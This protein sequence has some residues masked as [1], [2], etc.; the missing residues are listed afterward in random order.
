MINAFI[1]AAIDRSRT[2]IFILL[3]ILVSGIAAF[4]A[5]PKEA[6]PDVAIPIIY[7]SV[8]YEGISPDDAV[9]LL[10]RP[11][12]KE[13]KT[14]EGIKEMRSVGSEGHA[15][16]TL[17]F[18]AG[19]DSDSA[20]DDVREK[21]DIA[22][23]K[24][25]D[26]AEEPSINEV[27]VA[28]FPVLNIALSGAVPERVKLAAAKDLKEEIEGVAGVLKVDIGGE[29]EEMMEIII[30]PQVLESYQLD[31]SSILNIV[32]QNNQLVAA[33]AVDAGNGRQVLKV[34]GVVESIQDMLNMPIKVSGSTVVTLGDVAKIRKT[35]KDPAGY[36][37]VNG[38]SG[39]VLEVTKQV[40][41]NIIDTIEQVQ[42]IV[43]E[44]KESWP[45]GLKH[46]YILD[47]SI[48]IEDMLRDLMNNVLSG[49]IFVMIVILAVM[50]LRTSLLVGLAIPGSFLAS[51]MVLNMMGFTLNIV[52]LF[53]LILVVGML[54]DGAI[55]VAELAERRQQQGVS[56]KEAFYYASSRMAWPV[57]AGTA[58][59]LVVFMPLM[60]WPGII[61]Q[62]MKYLPATVIVCLTASLFMALIFLPVLGS[63]TGRRKVVASCDSDEYAL[64]DTAMNRSYRKVL[65]TALNYPVTSLITTLVF[66]VAT[67]GAYGTFGKGVE[68]F[69][70][71]EPDMVLI[72]LH[73]RGDLS[74]DE[75]DALLRQV[76]QRVEAVEGYKSIY[77]RSFNQAD[78]QSAEDVVGIIQ[79][80]LDDW[81]TRETASEILARMQQ[82]TADIPGVIVET[83][84]AESGPTQGKPFKLLV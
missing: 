52:V 24:L 22:K 47:Q 50:G 29:R 3:F 21:V 38:E 73:A 20:L 14:I 12:E 7:V 43:D 23:S 2:S 11:L 28:L 59:T 74:V 80:Q 71:V 66:I 16:V 41:A 32:S 72:N 70:D 60:F 31:F 9:R 27:N 15:S 8:A 78:S 69:P 84:K 48:Q 46:A 4:Q 62:F 25:P 49:I 13:L 51:M 81:D 75:K 6:D 19:F 65:G 67:Y 58:T 55:V 17:E 45:A 30:E 61:G 36:A 44:R 26:G 5:I 57:I 1:A 77:A 42:Q 18:D 64:P 35:F 39:L 34:P 53:S 10:V 76:E 40:G 56:A 63:V 68:F 83:R 54:V 33:G 37:R 79:F 82:L